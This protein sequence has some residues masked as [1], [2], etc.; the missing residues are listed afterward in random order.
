MTDCA[1]ECFD[2]YAFTADEDRPNPG[3]VPSRLP[4]EGAPGGCGNVRTRSCAVTTLYGIWRDEPAPGWCSLRCED[5]DDL[6]PT[7]HEK[8]GLRARFTR[9]FVYAGSRAECLTEILNYPCLSEA[10]VVSFDAERQPP[11]RSAKPTS[12]Q[13]HMLELVERH[14]TL[15]TFALPPNYSKTVNVLHRNGWIMQRL[16]ADGRLD[17]TARDLRLSAAGAAM[18]AGDKKEGR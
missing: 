11:T 8:F 14:G 9:Y 5:V 10:N 12:A 2:W 4:G 18:L 13:R 7:P 17:V 6:D 1:P 16:P 15:N 3:F